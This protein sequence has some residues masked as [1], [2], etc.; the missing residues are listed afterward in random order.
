MT[1]LNKIYE[2]MKKL[3]TDNDIDKYIND[4]DY[5]INNITIDVLLFVAYDLFKYGK[6][7]D[8]LMTTFER[9]YQEKF[10]NNLIKKYELCIITG[11]DEDICEACHII[12]H[13]ECTYDKK[14][15]INNGLLLCK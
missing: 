12:P 2:D 9:L 1:T 14:Y 15:D 3:A 6:Y 11:K 7:P 8:K 13:S 5:T 4:Y 10:R